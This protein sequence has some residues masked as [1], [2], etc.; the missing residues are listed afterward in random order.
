[1]SVTTFEK[2]YSGQG[3]RTTFQTSPIHYFCFVSNSEKY[4]REV[5]NNC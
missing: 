1:M 3:Q 5:L 2:L 4:T